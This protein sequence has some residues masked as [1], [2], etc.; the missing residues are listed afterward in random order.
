MASIV[1]SIFKKHVNEDDESTI[2]RF[3][4]IR[5]IMNS[6]MDDFMKSKFRKIISME[7]DL[8]ELGDD[9]KE[10][11][12]TELALQQRCKEKTAMDHNNAYAFIT[13]NPKPDVE[14]GDF[15]KKIEGYVKRSICLKYLYVIE[16]RGDTEEECGK[17]FHCHILVKRH[18]SYKPCKF[19]EN[20]FN[21]FKNLVGN[22][23]HVDVQ[24]VG[25]EFMKDK[26]EYILG[27]KT[28]EG[29]DVKQKFDKVFRSNNDI[30]DYYGE[31]F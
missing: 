26:Q 5:K 9:F 11:R 18:L 2:D 13:I 10:L 16:Q 4:N 6:S 29:K 22:K 30:R 24:F 28:K 20:T 31:T 21:T 17:G 12:Q 14:L 23:K 8:E 7:Y 1:E 19:R 27:T 15:M 3:L 25:E